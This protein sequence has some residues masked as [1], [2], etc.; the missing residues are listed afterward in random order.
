[1]GPFYSI[2]V[3]PFYVVKATQDKYFPSCLVWAHQEALTFH[4]L[5]AADV[6]GDSVRIVT[7]YKP[8]PDKW[9]SDLK[10]EKDQMKCTVCGGS[11]QSKKTN[12]PF[13]VTDKT[14]VILKELPIA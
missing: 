3:G 8:D 5:F 9:E 6:E 13:K 2:G 1:M 14:I 10:T 12:L 11:M 7:A 4:V